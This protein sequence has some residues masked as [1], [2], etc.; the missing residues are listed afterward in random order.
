MDQGP[1]RH[2]GFFTQQGYS[3]TYIERAS[4]AGYHHVVVPE[5]DIPGHCY[6]ALM[7]LPELVDPSALMQVRCIGAGL[8]Q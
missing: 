2:G 6:A 7:A 1:D 5:I 3:E 4:G 8:C